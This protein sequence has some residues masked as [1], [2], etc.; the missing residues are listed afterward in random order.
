[1]VTTSCSGHPAWLYDSKVVAELNWDKHM[2]IVSFVSR[3]DEQAIHCCNYAKAD[4]CKFLSL[5]NIKWVRRVHNV[6]A[7]SLASYARS[8]YL[9]FA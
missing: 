1:M 9:D 7:H 4:V 3:N 6:A 8:L 5:A 2:D